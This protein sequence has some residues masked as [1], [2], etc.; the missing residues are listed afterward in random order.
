[1]AIGEFEDTQDDLIQQKLHDQGTKLVG[2]QVVMQDLAYAKWNGLAGIIRSYDSWSDSFYVQLEN[3][4]HATVNLAHM[5]F[6]EQDVHPEA[7]NSR[8]VEE[9]VSYA[10][11]AASLGHAARHADARQDA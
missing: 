6:V 3:F 10:A 5:Q 7:V 1:M 2:V 4:D 9:Q 8:V 11:C